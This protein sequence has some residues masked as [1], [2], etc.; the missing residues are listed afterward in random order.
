MPLRLTRRKISGVRIKTVYGA[1]GS[2]KDVVYQD[3]TL[4]NISKYGVVIEQD[5]ENGSPTGKPT[6]GVPITGLTLNNVK[7]SVASKGTNIYVLCAS[8]ACS[9]WKWS[10][11]NVTGGK[12][13]TKCLNVPGSAKC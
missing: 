9:G 3:I 6:G 5:Y 7:G 12:T 13:S 11:V 4:S 1:T 2:V 8:G 10:G